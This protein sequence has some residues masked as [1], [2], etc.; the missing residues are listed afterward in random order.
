MSREPGTTRKGKAGGERD[1]AHPAGTK[2]ATRRLNLAGR[3]TVWGARDLQDLLRKEVRDGALIELELAAGDEIDTAGIQM[4]LA[5]RKSAAGC[6]DCR[7]TICSQSDRATG[8]LRRAGL[9]LS[10][11]EARPNDA[12]E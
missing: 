10:E 7:L 11:G 9:T 1:G 12:R 6:A 3:L 5:A 4:L 2:D 8:T